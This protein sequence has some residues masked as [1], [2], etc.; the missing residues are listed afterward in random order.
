MQEN[1]K[2]KYLTHFG[3]KPKDTVNQNDIVKVVKKSCP[4]MS[5]VFYTNYNGKLV[6]NLA[7][8]GV[9]QEG[10]LS[11]FRYFDAKTG[12]I[13]GNISTIK[14]LSD[15]EFIKSLENLK[16]FEADHLAHHGIKGQQWG[17]RN[18]PP[19]PLDQKEHNKVVNKV[20]TGGMQ[21]G[22]Q[23]AVDPLTAFY[24]TQLALPVVA[25]ATAKVL[26]KPIQKFMH[27]QRVKNISELSKD[28][29]TK[30]IADTSKKFSDD[31][32]P[33]M[34]KGKH[35]EEDDLK[36]INPTYD[37]SD[38]K[39]TNNCVLTSITYDLRRRGYDVVANLSN[40]GNMTD[41]MINDCYENVKG[42]K[43]KKAND[44]SEVEKQV[45]QNNPEGS[46]GVITCSG[47]MYGQ[48]F[49]H[50]MTY[51]IKNGRVIVRDPQSSETYGDLSTFV[52][53]R[54]EAAFKLFEPKT[55]E[56]FRL[57]N[58]KIKWSGMNQV[59]SE[60]LEGKKQVNQWAAQKKR[61]DA[62][63]KEHPNTTL[64]NKQILEVLNG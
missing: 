21:K 42:D 24:L 63:I 57:D 7:K 18:G 54:R 48:Y 10:Q 58:A 12:K 22:T 20:K 47:N 4:G 40:L 13:S 16:K 60:R 36:I 44:W 28:L 23:G 61:I 27:K 53:D 2:E 50:A 14:L 35:T 11:D 33:R 55:T 15:P 37:Q 38:P 3:I 31:N 34:I 6:V 25:L 39:S 59:C 41:L 46:R 49:G 43:Y 62:Y 19:Y 64:S 32:P 26:Q 1:L 30:K 56:T 5:P 8:T 52:K 29:D 45:L 17:V 9:S 51:E